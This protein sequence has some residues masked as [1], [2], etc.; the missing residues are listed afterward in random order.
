MARVQDVDP[1]EMTDQQRRI[2]REI[3]G[4]RGGVVRGPFA[5]WIRN[6]GLAD[7]ANKV[8]SELWLNG[9]LDK[10]LFEL[11]VLVV[12]RHWS[13]QYEWFAH[14][15]AALENGI[16]PD[17]VD[18][19]RNRPEP[20][21]K[22]Q[23]ERV[24]CEVT[25]EMLQPRALSDGTYARALEL[26]GLDILIELLAAIGFYTMVAITLVGFDAPVPGGAQPL[27]T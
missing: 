20:P 23:S 18:A 12:A 19:I 6:I 9:K 16:S 7:A 26:F 4:T 11:M 17:V 5:I 21:F 25:S 2:H 22:N 13:A 14:E 27:P 8:G 24:T 3:A 10:G 1:G 15:K